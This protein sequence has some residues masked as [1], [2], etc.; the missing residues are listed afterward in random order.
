VIL[1]PKKNKKILTKQTSLIENTLK[2]TSFSSIQQSNVRLNPIT[3]EF[4]LLSAIGYNE[5]INSLSYSLQ[6]TSWLT[7]A[8]F[9][10]IF[11]LF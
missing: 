5:L 11:Y 9:D 10:V 8:K 3:D 1:Q 6:C 2:E 7:D 4:L